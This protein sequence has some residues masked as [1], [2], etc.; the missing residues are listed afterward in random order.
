MSHTDRVVDSAMNYR[1]IQKIRLEWVLSQPNIG[2]IL[3][4]HPSDL[5]IKRI[6]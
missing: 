2:E 6:L 3:H 1:K 5:P 4:G